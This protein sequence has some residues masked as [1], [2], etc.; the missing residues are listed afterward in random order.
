MYAYVPL[1]RGGV[2]NA[3]MV[4]MTS[5]ENENQANFMWDNSV[6]PG[7]DAETIQQKICQGKC[8]AS[9]GKPYYVIIQ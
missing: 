3:G 4:V 8:P 6:T 1:R 9:G 7:S 2:D 5:V